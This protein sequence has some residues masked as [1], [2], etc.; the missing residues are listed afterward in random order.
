MTQADLLQAHL[1]NQ[2]AQQQQQQQ[3]FLEQ[4]QLIQQLIASMGH[5]LGSV[6]AAQPPLT[7]D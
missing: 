5:I 6:T 2:Q 4:Q 7:M 3:Q 1:Q